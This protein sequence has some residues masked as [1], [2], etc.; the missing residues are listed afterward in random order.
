[1]TITKVLSISATLALTLGGPALAGHA[2]ALA[3]TAVSADDTSDHK[4]VTLHPGDLLTVTLHSPGWNIDAPHGAALRSR[5]E[6]TVKLDRPGPGAP[7]TASR[8]FT[9]VAPGDA[10]VTA[11]RNSCGEALRCTPEQAGYVLTVHVAA[12]PVLPHTGAA[13]DAAAGLGLL[14]LVVGAGSVLLGRSRDGEPALS[15]P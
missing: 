15:A 7:G 2:Q 5:G 11:S 8:S 3:G 12:V 14:L 1:M 13:T 9:A 6:Q 10:T 4:A